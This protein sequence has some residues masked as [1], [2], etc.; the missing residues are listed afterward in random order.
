MKASRDLSHLLVRLKIVRAAHFEKTGDR[1]FE[2]KTFRTFSFQKYLLRSA[3]CR[4]KDANVMIV[5]SVDEVNEPFSLVAL[6]R[7][8]LRNMLDEYSIE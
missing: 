2:F 7:A 1:S 4:R 6:F 5:E 8:Q 3:G